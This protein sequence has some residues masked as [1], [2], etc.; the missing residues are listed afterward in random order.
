MKYFSGLLRILSGVLLLGFSLFKYFD[1][2]SHL[3]EGSTAELFG[4][5]LGLTN[6]TL[7]WLLIGVAVLGLLLTA[8]GIFTFLRKSN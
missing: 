2:R 3:D 4:Q 7:L 6:E 1:V 8:L 5:K